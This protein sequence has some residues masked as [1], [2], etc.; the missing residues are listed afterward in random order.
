MTTARNLACLSVFLLAACGADP[1]PGPVEQIIVR[2]PGAALVETA[3]VAG[4]SGDALI[5]EG[6]AAFANCSACHTL[7]QGAP[8][9]A[10][11]NLFG[12]VGKAAGKVAGFEYSDAL[13]AS[14]VTWT[15]AE[16]DSYIADPAAKI[17]GTTMVAGTI[18]DQAKRQAVI[19]YIESVTAN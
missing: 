9:G 6:K 4:D 3:A 19:A 12:I 8:N 1:A 17:P 15:A 11:P 2:E 13:K 18:A 5:A 14:G 10:G 7:Q 16:L